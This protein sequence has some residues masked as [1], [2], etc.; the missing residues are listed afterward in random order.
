MRNIINGK[1]AKEDMSKLFK[2]FGKV[3]FVNLISVKIKHITK[4]FKWII[5][6]KETHTTH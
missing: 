6:T 5:I 4:N 2:K 3:I 1:K